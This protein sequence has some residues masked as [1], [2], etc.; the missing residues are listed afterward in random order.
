MSDRDRLL[1][2]TRRHQTPTQHARVHHPPTDMP[3]RVGRIS[4]GR[5]ASCQLRQTQIG[6]T[7]RHLAS[8]IGPTTGADPFQA[9]LR[10]WRRAVERLSASAI[11]R[12]HLLRSPSRAWA[13]ACMMWI[14]ASRAAGTYCPAASA[15]ADAIWAPAF[16]WPVSRAW[17][18][19]GHHHIGHRRVAVRRMC[20]VQRPVEVPLREF[21]PPPIQ[22]CESGFASQPRSR[23]KQ[24]RARRDLDDRENI[25]LQIPRDHPPQVASTVLMIH[26]AERCGDRSDLL[27]IHRVCHGEWWPTGACWRAWAGLL[28]HECE[29]PGKTPSVASSRSN[30]SVSAR[31]GALSPFSILPIRAPE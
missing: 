22:G 9:G 27:D 2:P 12:S 15:A 28:D 10:R 4:L 26:A 8:K 31:F 23:H 5:S 7:M 18:A 21:L 6:V 11:S 24:G 17:C 30:D 29:Q 16:G 1:Q 19:R 25:A 20:P 13:R 14:F 3:Y